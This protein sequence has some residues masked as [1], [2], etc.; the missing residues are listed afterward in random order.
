M[1]GISRSI[2]LLVML[3]ST[4]GR[5]TSQQPTLIA[6][7]DPTREG[8]TVQTFRIASAILK[9]E[10]QI[11]IVLPASY[12]NS[13]ATRTYPVTIVFDGE[14]NTT[15]VASVSDD[16]TMHGQ[17][18][19]SIIVGIG[20]NRGSDQEESSR[21][22]VHDLTPPGLS[23]SGSGRSE[24]GD[25]FLDFIEKELLPAV[26]RQFRGGRP[27]TIIGHSSGGILATY[28]AATRP[29]FRSI[30]AIDTPIQLDDNFLPKRLQAAAAT[31]NEPLRYVSFEARFGWTDK[32]WKELTA[33]APTRW[34]LYREHLA[35]ETHESMVM[36]A[37]YLGLRAIYKDYAQ[38][39]AP[40]A[41]TTSIL[42]YYD[43]VSIALGARV[44][45]PRQLLETVIEDL[46]SEGRG[47]LARAAFKTLVD[48]YG[49]PA[50]SSE[51][52]KRIADVEQR[53]SPTETVEGL[54]ATPFPTAE[55]MRP[56]LG[57]WK[58]GDWM[59][60]EEAHGDRQT[61]RI[62]IVD[63]KVV[64]ETVTRLPD[65]GEMT[66]KWTYLQV[67]PQGLTWGFMNGMRPRGVLLFEGK[68]ADG[69][70]SGLMRFGGVSF[71]MRDGSKPPPI[72]FSFTKK[73]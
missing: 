31:R 1:R 29:G 14:Y 25:S 44:P 6:G 41:P 15:T 50:N 22:R 52:L 11:F 34:Q 16:L 20:N 64:G 4:Y 28:A 36:L 24:G 38:T 43:G 68:F 67:T 2:I 30:I 51:L 56:F 37:S 62:R 21:N 57:E 46:L 5:V 70:L 63:G 45:P 49:R 73:P 69:T 3:V 35:D 60:E 53:P 33:A 8:P 17:I 39:S 55:Q 10:R 9:Q 19:E 48:G 18:P 65:G 47:A 42:A 72:H 54:L 13:A 58:G 61:L 71:V 23:V 32:G 40:T 26:E 7:S 27:R 59:S 12:G 66:S